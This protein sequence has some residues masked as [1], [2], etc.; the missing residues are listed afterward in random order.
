MTLFSKSWYLSERSYPWVVIDVLPQSAMY[1]CYR[2]R[3]Q[4]WKMPLVSLMLCIVLLVMVPLSFVSCPFA[5][6]AC[7]AI[8]SIALLPQPYH[9]VQKYMQDTVHV[10][11]NTVISRCM[12]KPQNIFL[13]PGTQQYPP[14][15]NEILVWKNT[16]QIID[17]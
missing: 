13:F 8:A 16:C 17:Y 1:N 4:R 11:G 3:W 9:M 2:H 14:R 15:D 7:V 10:L 12:S 5:G 6:S